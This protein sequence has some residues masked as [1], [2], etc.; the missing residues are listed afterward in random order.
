MVEIVIKLS[1]RI[2]ILLILFP[3]KSVYG[4]LDQTILNENI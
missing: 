3:S 1:R 4:T 2:A